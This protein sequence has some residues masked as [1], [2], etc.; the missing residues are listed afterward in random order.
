MS[1]QDLIQR[2][3]VL[4]PDLVTIA[5]GN[6]AVSDTTR[7]QSK[8]HAGVLI[9]RI[10]FL[11]RAP[12]LTSV[13][14]VLDFAPQIGVKLMV[15]PHPLM[16]EFVP[17][18]NLC[19]TMQ[20]TH[21]FCGRSGSEV[22]SQAYWYSRYTWKLP[23]PM[24]V[25]ASMPVTATWSRMADSAFAFGGSAGVQLALV[26]HTMKQGSRL[27][28]SDIPFAS[29]YISPSATD[30]TTVNARSNEN[31]LR[32][33]LDK[34]LHVQRLVGRV[35]IA[36]TSAP[37]QNE[38]A[39]IVRSVTNA[40]IYDWRGYNLTGGLNSDLIRWADTFSPDRRSWNASFDLPPTKS[41]FV[42]VNN[43]T[44]ASGNSRTAMVGI[45]GWRKEKL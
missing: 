10:N 20:W 12:S 38:D 32:N 24:Y 43:L 1:Y 14:T 37:T 45:V 5:S 27:G 8:V 26:G 29:R 11:I 9:H 31:D 35:R 19:E 42:E 28:E 21:F 16:S 44:S 41:V 39:E 18:W 25:P 36:S 40:R 6:T 33:T 15:G 13:A 23:K 30:G 4:S 22:A 17:V 34:D 2:P 3:I 7:L